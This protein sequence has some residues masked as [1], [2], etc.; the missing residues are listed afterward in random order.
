MDLNWQGTVDIA[1]PV[2]R[3]YGYLADF[4]KH[5]E[6]AQ[7]LE[8]MEVV[9][10]GGPDGMGTVYKSWERQA[11]QN[12]RKPKGPFPKNAS[13]GTTE[14][15]IT[16]MKPNSRIAWHAHPVPVGMGVHADLA[17]DLEPD[18]NGGTRLTQTISMHQPW[19]VA[20][21]MGRFAFKLAPEEMAD[22]GKAQWQASLENIK[23]ILESP[24]AA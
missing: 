3:V 19:L 16:E 4:P 17:F 24:A 11:F 6:W 14:C 15:E 23:T 9:R 12:D 18:D 5:C 2:E 21:L 20:N 7:T 13:Q 8:R 1:A 22:K 10:P